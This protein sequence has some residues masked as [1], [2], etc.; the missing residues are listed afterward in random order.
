MLECIQ[1]ASHLRRCLVREIAQRVASDIV[2]FDGVHHSSQWLLEPS[3]YPRRGNGGTRDSD[4]AQD[5][6]QWH[7]VFPLRF[8]EKCQRRQHDSYGARA[9]DEHRPPREST[10]H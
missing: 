3:A 8:W 2:D 5:G 10:S 1:Q 6:C 4:T 7:E 9:C